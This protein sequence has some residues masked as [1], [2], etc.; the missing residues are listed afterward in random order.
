[1]SG[2]GL[3]RWEWLTGRVENYWGQEGGRLKEAVTKGL[4]GT[5]GLMFQC[6]LKSCSF[7]VY[8]FCAPG[9]LGVKTQKPYNRPA[10]QQDTLS[11]NNASLSYM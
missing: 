10:C 8:L 3:M 6:F 9:V 4:N 7:A 1:M 2:V 5:A 11:A